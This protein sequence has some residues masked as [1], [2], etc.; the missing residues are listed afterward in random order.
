M[1]KAHAVLS[2][3]NPPTILITIVPRF[4]DGSDGLLSETQKKEKLRYGEFDEKH[5]E[6]NVLTC[7]YS[8]IELTVAVILADYLAKTV[9]YHT[10]EP[11]TTKD[12]MPQVVSSKGRSY[13]PFSL[14]SNASCDVDG[15]DPASAPRR[16][17]HQSFQRESSLRNSKFKVDKAANIL[18]SSQYN[19]RR[20]S[21]A[22][23]QSLNV[24]AP[25]LRDALHPE[26]QK[27]LSQ[28]LKLPTI[29][30]DS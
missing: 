12:V 30:N 29:I 8:R 2:V 16:A 19:I 11:S 25:F 28:R 20:R 4:T 17:G 23:S 13:D 24:V 26:F 9:T 18:N 15:P 3:T 5:I 1:H 21:L 22:V 14:R 10:H 7:T 27:F 6:G